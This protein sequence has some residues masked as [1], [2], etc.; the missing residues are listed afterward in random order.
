M[1]AWCPGP[2][3]I[4]LLLLL[5]LRLLLMSS[6]WA[7]TVEGAVGGG[8]GGW[9]GERDES[10]RAGEEEGEVGSSASLC[11]PV[12]CLNPGRDAAPLHSSSTTMSPCFSSTA[13][14]Q[15]DRARS[16]VA[17]PEELCLRK[18]ARQ[19]PHTH[20]T[21]SDPLLPRAHTHVHTPDPDPEPI[22]PF[23]HPPTPTREPPEQQH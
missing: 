13:V 22:R 23:L 12:C 3:L 8:G 15:E 7:A 17:S 10:L 2:L 16:S 11:H 20:L 19:P 4:I 5:P 1:S 21:Q 9:K 14:T 18:K 6:R